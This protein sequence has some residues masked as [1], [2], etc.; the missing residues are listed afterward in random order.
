MTRKRIIDAI[1]EAE[2]ASM[3]RRKENIARLRNAGVR[4][5]TPAKHVKNDVGETGEPTTAALAAW[6]AKDYLD[7]FLSEMKLERPSFK[8]GGDAKKFLAQM[9]RFLDI[10]QERKPA[11]RAIRLLLSSLASAMPTLCHQWN[12]K[13][14]V[15]PWILSAR[16]DQILEEFDHLLY[17]EDSPQYLLTEDCDVAEVQAQ[18][19]ATGWLLTLPSG[20]R[21]QILSS[22]TDKISNQQLR[23]LLNLG[24]VDPIDDDDLPR[25]V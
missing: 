18:K 19:T 21:L 7:H 24:R 4:F 14:P 10:L 9:R 17:T 15:G 23:R 20:K 25:L 3:E 6:T 1:R 2:A 8:P 13:G 16:A 5:K 22:E 11:P 12:I